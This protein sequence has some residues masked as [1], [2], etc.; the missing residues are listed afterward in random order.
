MKAQQNL[1][2]GAVRRLDGL[3]LVKNH[4]LPSDLL[5]ILRILDHQLIRCN[6]DVEF[7]IPGVGNVLSVPEFAENL[8]V[9][10]TAPV[11]QHFDGWNKPGDFLLPIV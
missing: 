9:F 4:V 5:E 1:P 11:R 3:R 7:R 6:Q 8:S 2:P 10:G